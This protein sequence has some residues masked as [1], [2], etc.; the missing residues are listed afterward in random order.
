MDFFAI[1]KTLAI[2]IMRSSEHSF[3][4]TASP[5]VIRK[6]VEVLLTNLEPLRSC[7]DERTSN[8]K[9]E[10]RKPGEVVGGD[11]AYVFVVPYPINH[12]DFQ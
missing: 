8:D 6:E 1:T 11:L 2:P 10:H 5:N 4:P 7:E 9:Q 3:S 12:N